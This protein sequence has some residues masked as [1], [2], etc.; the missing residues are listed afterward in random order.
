MSPKTSR[1]GEG[2]KLNNL[3]RD[4][5]AEILSFLDSP[6]DWY[7]F[8]RTC[9]EL[10]EDLVESPETIWGMINIVFIVT[11]G[12]FFTEGF[13]PDI[14]RRIK[15]AKFREGNTHASDVLR[16]VAKM[17][18]V[19]LTR[20]SVGHGKYGMVAELPAMNS[21]E[22]LSLHGDPPYSEQLM[23]NLITSLKSMPK[24]R[25]LS[26]RAT[27]FFSAD[28]HATRAM[29]DF[30]RGATSLRNVFVRSARAFDE[31]REIIESPQLEWVSIGH[32]IR[33]AQIGA[34][35]MMV[36]R[37]RKTRN[38]F[39]LELASGPVVKQFHHSVNR[40]NGI[41]FEGNID[42]GGARYGS[43]KKYNRT[44]E[45]IESGWYANDRLNGAGMTVVTRGYDGSRFVIR[46]T[47]DHGDFTVNPMSLYAKNAETNA[48]VLI[49][50]GML[51]WDYTVRKVINSSTAAA[52][53][54]NFKDDPKSTQS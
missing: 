52:A 21:I 10:R 2:K 9:K 31:I 39:R 5:L 7:N 45:V 27:S 19:S 15:N 4:S 47:F 44:G 23:D 20:M 1:G 50:T 42:S 33:P 51:D 3:C 18:G 22:E 17:D 6:K 49:G 25:T 46:G 13:N 26:L 38:D 30:I 16:L 32:P 24:L 40:R 34:Q 29:T 35:L 53:L 43:C 11:P 54:E 41:K 28:G 8:A 14:F 48:E 37:A 12:I 36:A